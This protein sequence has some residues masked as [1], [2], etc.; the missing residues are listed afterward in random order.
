MKKLLFIFLLISSIAFGAKPLVVGMEL[1]YPP[2]ETTDSAGNP[3]GLSVDLANDLGAYLG[4]KVEIHNMSYGGLIPALMTKKVDIVLSSMSITPRRARAI[5]FSIPYAHSNLAILANKKSNITKPMD[6]NKKG[7]KIAVKR[8]TIGHIQ[9]MKS[10]PKATI[11]VFDKESASM[12]EVIQGKVDAFIYDPLTLLKNWKRNMDKTDIILDSFEKEPQNW[13]I[14]FRKG[15]KELEEKVNQFIREYK[16]K[17]GFD[18]L[19][20]KYL[21]EQKKEFEKRNLPF[22]F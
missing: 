15:N 7:I 9:A 20:E 16:A 8:G 22:F 12:L 19:A 1:A 5:D 13:G 4:R 6:L 2:F 11:L 14:G 3:S 21:S 10:F 18:K 17:G